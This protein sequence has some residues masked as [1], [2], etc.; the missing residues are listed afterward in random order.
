MIMYRNLLK[1][2]LLLIGPLL[3]SLKSPAYLTSS[4]DINLGQ[5]SFNAKTSNEQRE[6]DSF[7]T[8]EM[9]YSLRNSSMGVSYA[10]SF[11]ELVNSKEGSLA[12]TR[13]SFGP[14]WYPLGMNGNKVLIDNDVIA[15][16]WKATPYLG[17]SLGLTNLSTKD[18]NASLFDLGIRFGVE[19]PLSPSLLLNAQYIISQSFSSSSK[20]EASNVSYSGNSITIG[21]LV[22]GIAD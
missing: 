8:L 7:S 9:N 11:F 12:M 16:I 13:L 4:F 14:R 6:I 22:S 15:K 10:L 2:T 17:G 19:V 3:F 21:V 18:Y 1:S 5:S 20:G